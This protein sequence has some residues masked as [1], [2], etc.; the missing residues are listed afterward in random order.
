[1]ADRHEFL[2][3]RLASPIGE[4]AIMADGDGRLRGLAWGD[5]LTSKRRVMDR[6]YGPGT[7][8]LVPA[9]DPFG[10]TS[11][12]RRYFAGDLHVI[13]DLPVATLGSDFQRA[14]W[15]E[16]RRIPCGETI[17]YGEMARRVG[18]AGAA[19]AVGVANNANPIGI[20][21][22]CHRVIGADGRLVGFGG[23]MDRK[24]WLLSHE[25]RAGRTP[26]LPF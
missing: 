17:S 14:V 7:Y 22:P 23:G 13:D 21:V 10:L 26:E 19:R 6:H 9:A 15:A 4:L 20:V 8:V 2:I 3:D 12:L 16:L 11:A 25:S 18:D 5:R 24:R 1:L